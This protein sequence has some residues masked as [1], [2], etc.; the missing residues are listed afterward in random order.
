MLHRLR[1]IMGNIPKEMLTGTVE[2]DETYMSRKYG[3]DY[4]GMS[5][6][7]VERMEQADE[8]RKKRN[9]GAVIGM[10]E[11]EG[12]IIVKASFDAKAS[13]IEQAVKENVSTDALLNT[14]ESMKYR[15]LLSS[16]KR[17]SV[18]HSKHQWVKG[19]VSTNGVENF[20]SVMKRGVYGIY[21]Q[22]SYTPTTVL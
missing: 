14:D 11:R 19:N 7:A 20:W 18:N 10:K 8:Y 4:V 2:L 12:N 17:E 15:N 3:S 21:H 22:I 6:E 1:E 13:A 16:Y 9:L 5:P